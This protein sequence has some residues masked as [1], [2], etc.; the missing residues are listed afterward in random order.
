MI[1]IL[2]L[3]IIFLIAISYFSKTTESFEDNVKYE[4][5]N[6]N[7]LQDNR[8]QIYN[9]NYDKEWKEPPEAYNNPIVKIYGDSFNDMYKMNQ[10]IFNDFQKEDLDKFTKEYGIKLNINKKQ[11]FLLDY[12]PFDIYNLNKGPCIYFI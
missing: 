4:L 5:V 11:D 12:T 10:Y 2:L 1:I 3:T 9:Q 7:H 8:F 6:G